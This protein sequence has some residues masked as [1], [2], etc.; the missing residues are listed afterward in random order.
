MPRSVPASFVDDIPEY[1]VRDGQ[2]HICM[3]GARLVMP[4]HVFRAGMARANRVLDAW[5]E[6][7][8]NV[9]PFKH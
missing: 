3:A 9:V 4:V 2:M 8:S 7:Q 1:E 6:C 5:F